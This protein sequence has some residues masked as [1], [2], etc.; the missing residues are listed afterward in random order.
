M[1]E[2]E[3]GQK[4]IGRV[5]FWVRS[6]HCALGFARMGARGYGRSPKAGDVSLS[7]AAGKDHRARMVLAYRDD[8]HSGTDQAD[9]SPTSE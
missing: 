6:G 1:S 8:Q 3:P 2:E 5:L 4:M 7:W 9:S